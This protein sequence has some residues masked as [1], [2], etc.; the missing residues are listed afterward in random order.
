M[1][2]EDEFEMDMDIEPE[3]LEALSDVMEHRVVDGKVY[4][5]VNGIKEMI[6]TYLEGV[7]DA[8]QKGL[9]CQHGVSMS[10]TILYSLDNLMDYCTYA[11]ADKLV[12]DTIPDDIMGV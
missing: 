12:P 1:E 5:S 2:N 6:G 9:T 7:L 10:G 11:N 8:S 3:V 4:V